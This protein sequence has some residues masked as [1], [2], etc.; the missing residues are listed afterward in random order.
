MLKLAKI[1]KNLELLQQSVISENKS[2]DLNFLDKKYFD[3]C[4]ENFFE[5]AAFCLI[6]KTS[7]TKN[8]SEILSFIK[9]HALKISNSDQELKT[10]LLSRS[11]LRFPFDLKNKRTSNS[12]FAIAILKEVFDGAQLDRVLQTM[13]IYFEQNGQSAI[14][15]DCINVAMI[16][17]PENIEF[18]YT[19]SLINISLGQKKIALNHAE[20][21]KTSSK[22][23]YDFLTFFINVCFQPFGFINPQNEFLFSKSKYGKAPVTVLKEIRHIQEK[24]KDLMAQISRLRKY[25]VNKL[26]KTLVA[27]LTALEWLPTDFSYIVGE[28]LISSY[29]LRGR[30]YQDFSL[31]DLLKESR[32]LSRC[33][34]TICWSVG[35]NEI[36]IPT[37]I[38]LRDSFEYFVPEVCAR[39]KF[40]S[41]LEKN[42]PIVLSEFS[43]MGRSVLDWHSQ[44]LPYIESDNYGLTESVKFLCNREGMNLNP[45]EEEFFFKFY[46]AALTKKDQAA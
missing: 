14:A 20:K 35:Y 1:D 38:N 9:K 39:S 28:D 34:S 24:T 27:D 16:L 15:N 7:V 22:E 36:C 26:D 19:A 37:E 18:N 17:S 11:Y 32:S 43:L 44:L 31:T 8:K 5:G 41:D 4:K 25:I 3:F 10:D 13:A 42:F 33:L 21:V 30:N 40:M 6:R 12:A 29:E 2:I 23:K 46:K 45:V